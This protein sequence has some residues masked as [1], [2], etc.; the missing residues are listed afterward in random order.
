MMWRW[1]R[2]L[3]RMKPTIEE[4]HNEL[5]DAFSENLSRAA[6]NYKGGVF[7]PEMVTLEDMKEMKH[8]KLDVGH[9]LATESRR[10]SLLFDLRWCTPVW[11]RC[12][13]CEAWPRPVLGHN[14]S[15]DYVEAEEK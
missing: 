9:G 4:M 14:I 6:I 5:L 10:R 12:V 2:K 15:R 1:V 3:L 8:V 13:L 7:S 11:D